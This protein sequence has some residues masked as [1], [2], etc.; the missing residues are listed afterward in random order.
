MD[1][2]PDEGL[3]DVRIGSGSPTDEETAAVIA[4]LQALPRIT[5]VGAPVAPS[6]W[7]Q[8]RRSIRGPL[9]N[10]TWR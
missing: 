4:V 7:E 3:A 8:N 10:S 5:S 1:G 2:D 6:G 9:H